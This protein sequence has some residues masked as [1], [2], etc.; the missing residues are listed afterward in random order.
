MD[1]IRLTPR[2]HE[3]A[4]LIATGRSNA[5]IARELGLS[6]RTVKMHVTALRDRLGVAHR[7]QVPLAYLRAT[8]KSP[9]D[10]EDGRAA[11]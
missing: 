7:R 4:R 11:A 1:E 8:G 5:E 10:G 3:V 6:P 9:F 2:Q